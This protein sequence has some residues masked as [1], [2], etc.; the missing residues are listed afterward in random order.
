M[1]TVI[2]DYKTLRDKYFPL[3]MEPGIGEEIYYVKVD[4]GWIVQMH[5]NSWYIKCHVTYKDLLKEAQ[6]QTY[7]PDIL[8]ELE[9]IIY[10]RNREKTP[11][12]LTQK[13]Q[14]ELLKGKIASF[15][16]TFLRKAVEVLGFENEKGGKE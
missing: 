4:K 13:D 15:E 8:R 1:K 7:R 12:T 16:V 3:F 9:D 6:Q 2:I 14:D 11:Y 10:G 5:K